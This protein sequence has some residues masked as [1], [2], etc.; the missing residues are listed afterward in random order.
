MHFF[1]SITVSMNEW[2]FK[3]FYFL[4]TIK[5]LLRCKHLLSSRNPTIRLLT[6]DTIAIACQALQSHQG[7]VYLNYTWIF[8]IQLSIIVLFVLLIVWTM[9]SDELLPMIHEIWVPFSTRFVDQEKLVTKKVDVKYIIQV[10]LCGYK[11]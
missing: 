11:T 3:W 4:S 8:I 1:Y 9:I 2:S 5:V 10:H 7:K 6:L